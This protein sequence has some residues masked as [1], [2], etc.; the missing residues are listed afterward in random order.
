ML[1]R[2]SLALG[3]CWYALEIGCRWAVGGMHPRAKKPRKGGTVPGVA[4]EKAPSF[5]VACDTGRCSKGQ[6]SFQSHEQLSRSSF[7]R[8]AT[9]W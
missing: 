5:K 9:K 4:E 6:G 1:C 7:Y 8:R 2:Y 3:G